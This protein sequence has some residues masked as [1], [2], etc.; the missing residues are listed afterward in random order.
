MHLHKN[1]PEYATYRLN[2][3]NLLVFFKFFSAEGYISPS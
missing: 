2:N 1:A 3:R